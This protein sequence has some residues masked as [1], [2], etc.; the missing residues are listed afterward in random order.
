MRLLCLGFVIAVGFS[1]TALACT[2][3]GPCDDGS[4]YDHWVQQ[5]GDDDYNDRNRNNYDSPQS[6]YDTR[7]DENWTYG[8]RRSDG[9]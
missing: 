8:S 6:Q 5:H 4:P 2:F 9:D 3:G 7:R 1:G